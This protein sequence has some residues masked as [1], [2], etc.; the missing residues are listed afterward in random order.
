M[1]E[2]PA[3]M[4]QLYNSPSVIQF[5]TFNEDD[6]VD[7]FDAAAVVAWAR[8]RDP[9]RLYNTDSGGPANSLFVADVND[10]HTYP[11]PG[12][13]VSSSSPLQYGMLGEYGGVGFIVKGAEWSPGGCYAYETVAS[14]E[15]FANTLVAMASSI[16]SLNNDLSAVYYTQLSDL[17]GQCTVCRVGSRVIVPV[18]LSA[19]GSCA[20]P[21]IAASFRSPLTA[22]ECDGL[23][24]YDRSA[25]FNTAQMASVVA[26]NIAMIA[27]GN[28]AVP[29]PTPSPTPWGYF[30]NAVQSPAD[31]PDPGVAW[32]PMTGLW[33]AATT[34]GNSLAGGGRFRLWNSSHLGAWDAAG[35]AFPTGWPGTP[36]WASG[37]YWAPELRAWAGT[38][39]LFFAATASSS[40]MLCVGVAVSSTGGVAGPY[41]DVGAPLISDT[42]MG[43][44]DPTFFV[45]SSNSPWLI[46]KTDGNAVGAAT[47]IRIAA[48]SP[49]GTGLLSGQ[50]DWHGTALISNTLAWEAG[51]VEAPWLM[52]VNGSFF[53][54]YS[55]G[56]YMGGY[57]VSVAR[58][59]TLTGP[60]TKLGVRLLADNGSASAAWQAPG[61]CSVVELPTSM[62]LASQATS[63]SVAAA[64][65]AVPPVAVPFMWAMIY[66]AYPGQSRVARWMMLDPLQFVAN[67]TGD[68][69]V[70]PVLAAGASWATV[71]NA[72]LAP[73]PQPGAAQ[74]QLPFGVGGPAVAATSAATATVT[75]T[76]SLSKMAS[77]SSTATQS[78]TASS[79]ST[80]VT[81]STS[82]SSSAFSASST[83][84]APATTSQ[85][86]S[87]TFGQPVE[88]VAVR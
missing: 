82:S 79:M 7:L 44:I 13:A 65:T 78:I 35:T 60:Y 30:V 32:D 56:G 39:L 21:T 26:A 57:S 5:E 53:L 77:I 12:D 58:A 71:G 51:I 22:D 45:D 28:A 20:S 17:E 70:W 63:A 40:G 74:Q 31:S 43:Q 81:T 9:T 86:P 25:K 52:Q 66:H 36:A 37:N 3:W 69:S 4:D 55:A 72:L 76:A 19:P 23:V 49:N 50:P 38:W 18:Q 46:W 54:F 61:H 1:N 29:T 33:W 88:L 67:A 6:C 64:G 42:S 10:L 2:A 27:A 80:A 75:A 87:P 14:A 73:V 34:S 83:R 68:G 16:V 41:N 62:G 84:I 15:S 8:A 24:N 85:T 48:L 47:S 11:N 59:S